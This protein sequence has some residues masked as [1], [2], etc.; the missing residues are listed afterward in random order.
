MRL[1]FGVAVCCV[2]V[3]GCASAVA[4]VHHAVR[5][6]SRDEKP[7]VLSVA[8]GKVRPAGA[9]RTYYAL[10]IRAFDPDGQIVSWSYRQLVQTGARVGGIGDGSC[11]LGGRRNGRVYDSPLPIKKLRPGFYRFLITVEGSTCTRDARLGSASRTFRI[12]VR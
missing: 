8:Y 5:S 3:A 11:G 12:H 1:K 9:S 4:S 7:R 10:S 6:A 2:L